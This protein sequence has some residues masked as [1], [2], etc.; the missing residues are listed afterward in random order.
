MKTKFQRLT[1]KKR[2]SVTTKVRIS[3]EAER[4]NRP[5]LIACQMNVD[6]TQH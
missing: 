6:G 5:S 2:V 1:D 4:G 3:T